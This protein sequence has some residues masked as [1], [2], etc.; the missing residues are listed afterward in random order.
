MQ[1]VRPRQRGELHG[2]PEETL[3]YTMKRLRLGRP[4][5]TAGGARGPKG[6]TAAVLTLRTTG[7]APEQRWVMKN[8]SGDPTTAT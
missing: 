4:P 6:A 8:R 7:E 1:Y 2:A 5:S 3:R